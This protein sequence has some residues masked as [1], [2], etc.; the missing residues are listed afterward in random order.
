MIRISSSPVQ[1]LLHC[2]TFLLYVWNGTKNI[3]YG[4]AEEFALFGKTGVTEV[5]RTALMSAYYKLGDNV[6]LTTADKFYG[7]S[8]FKGHFDGDGRTITLNID[9]TNIVESSDKNESGNEVAVG[10]SSKR[11]KLKL[12][13]GE[14]TVYVNINM[15]VF[16]SAT[17]AKIENFNTSGS[18]KV[19][20]NS[21][22]TGVVIGES[23][24]C[25][26]KNITNE[27][28]LELGAT[29]N[30]S[31]AGGIA[32]MSAAPIR[33]VLWIA[34]TLLRSRAAHS[35]RAWA[36]ALQPVSAPIRTH[37]QLMKTARTAVR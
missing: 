32:G 19:L 20:T 29:D 24:G 31:W 5:N 34:T 3:C 16:N 28:T 9:T 11:G 1:T 27:A 26:I 12:T 22:F 33:R 21:A 6:T 25:T 36:T 35:T 8:G 7:I 10:A 14:S 15:G 37:R 23:Y 13:I 18:A 17:G 4:T 30:T 2:L